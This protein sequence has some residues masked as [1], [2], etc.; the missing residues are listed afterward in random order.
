MNTRNIF[1]TTLLSLMALTG[2][3]Q[4]SPPAGPQSYSFSLQD[5]IN[6]AYEHQ[7][8][9]KNAALD[10]KSAEYRV[11]ETIGQGLPQINGSAQFQDYFKT[12]AQVAPGDFFGRPGELVPLRFAVKYS[13]TLTL[14]ATQKI[15]DGSFIV[16]LKSVK[17]FKELSQRSLVRSRIETN[18]NVSKAYY[19]VLVNDEQVK[20]L[21]ANLKQL[22]QQLDE[23]TAQNKQGFV[24]KI[25]VDRLS[26]QYNNLLTNRENVVRS[27][28]LNYQMLKFQMGMPIED[29]LT[30]TD[31]LDNVNL[32]NAPLSNN[33]DTSFYRKRIEYQL[34]ETNKKLN[35]FDL[36]EK[37]ARF[38]PTLSAFGNVS[39]SYYENRL[40]GL[41]DKN[42]PFS[43]IGLTL[44]VPIFSGGQ[45][46]NQ[47]RQSKIEVLKAQ[48]NLDH[49]KD[50]LKLQANAANVTYVNGLQSLNNQKNNQVLAQEV[51]RVS[52]IKY[53]QG[54]GSSIEVSQAQTA[55]EQANNQYIEA[56]Y[57]VLVSKVDLDKAYGR[58]Q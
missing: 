57:N 47:V 1:L 43:F 37:K 4:Q 25:D 42:Y 26:V 20:L 30:L 58:I 12:P 55:L 33:T 48:N 56:L 46:T 27:L 9:V 54:V 23:T 17:T 45:R 10:V 29:D 5:A 24:E 53:Q 41:F 51:L 36:Q 15:F 21:D 32:A 2:F 14:Q 44:N 6:Y 31:K 35:E 50:A 13:T 39:T 7:D 19:Q 38:L 49:L 8:S 16:G 34:F 11:K 28:F 40:G 52:R 3:A 18:V 22:K